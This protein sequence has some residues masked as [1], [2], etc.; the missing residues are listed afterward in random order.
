MVK[1]E[2]RCCAVAAIVSNSAISTAGMCFVVAHPGL[3]VAGWRQYYRLQRGAVCLGEWGHALACVVDWLGS[4]WL[5]NC[6]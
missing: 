3:F 2:I 6:V 4:L 1:I 5:L